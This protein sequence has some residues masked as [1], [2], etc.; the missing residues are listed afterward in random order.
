LPNIAVLLWG[1]SP[2]GWYVVA[3]VVRGLRGGERVVRQ[4][5]DEKAEGPLSV[6]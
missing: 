2:G 6:W 3:D 4:F 1:R 5:I